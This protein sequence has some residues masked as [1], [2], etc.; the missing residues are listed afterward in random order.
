MRLAFI[1]LAFLLC[2][3]HCFSQVTS[4][5]QEAYARSV[6]IQERMAKAISEYNNAKKITTNASPGLTFN[7]AEKE[8]KQ[9]SNFSADEIGI[10]ASTAFEVLQV[11]DKDNCILKSDSAFVWLSGY[12]TENLT[13]GV[14]V[15]IV[16]PV[17]CVGQKQYAALSGA[18]KTIPHFTLAPVDY[19]KK[20]HQE[21]VDREYPEFKFKNG[22]SY[23]AKVVSY[24]EKTKIFE[25]QE[26]NGETRKVRLIDLVDGPTK[27]ELRKRMQDADKGKK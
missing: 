7:Q 19:I 15:R 9:A 22:T 3:D 8:S 21:R 27:D 25:V 6:A 18:S 11:V 4:G 26:P 17:K 20:W 2:T 10:V 5:S 23:R 24:T 12:N 14:S 13:D 16:E 1:S